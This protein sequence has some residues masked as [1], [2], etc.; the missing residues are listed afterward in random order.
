M[1]P[2]RRNR[3]LSFLASPAALALSLALSFAFFAND[4]EA[5]VVE[6][7]VAVVGERAILLSDL[8]ERARPYLVQVRLKVPPG[9]QQAAAE[10]QVL[11]ELLN[12]MIDEELEAQAAKKAG[13]AVKDEEIT[14]ALENIASAQGMTVDSLYKGAT[15]QSGMTRQE[16]RDELRRQILEGKM[17]QLR[18]K[19]RVRLTEDDMKT[20]FDRAVR[21]EKRRREYRPSWIVLR[22]MPGS[23][24]AAIAE[25]KALAEELMNRARKGEDFAELAKRFSDDPATRD[26]GG[27]LGIRAPQGSPNALSGKRPV[28][29]PDLEAALMNMEAGQVSSPMQVSDAIVVM[30][31]IDRQASRFTSFEEARPEMMQRLQNEVMEKAKRRWLEDMRRRTHLDIRL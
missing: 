6:R 27:D 19:G 23:S 1:H 14:A 31:L 3:F 11:K 28:M 20:M 15:S 16:Y 30:K 13:V 7:I 17:V 4:A 24:A 29:A 9:A 18:V 8:R 10:S 5:I 26:K 12:K 25:R 21:E 2:R 22:I